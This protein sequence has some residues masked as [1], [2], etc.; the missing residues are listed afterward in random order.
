[1]ARSLHRSIEID[2]ELDKWYKTHYPEHSYSWLVNLLLEKF[3]DAHVNTPAD[4]AR[5]GAEAL[6]KELES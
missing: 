6:R 3:K 4:L 2:S 1:M 5:L